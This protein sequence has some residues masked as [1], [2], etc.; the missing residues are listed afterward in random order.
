MELRDTNTVC[1]R[2]LS[3]LLWYS[4]TV[5]VG[6]SVRSYICALRLT[7]YTRRQPFKRGVHPLT[8]LNPPLINGRLLTGS[9][10]LIGWTVM[11]PVVEVAPGS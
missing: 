4:T 3:Y 1:H 6:R 10:N 5:R 8:P 2:I 9:T 7:K 11:T